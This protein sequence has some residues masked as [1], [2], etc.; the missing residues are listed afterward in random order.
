MIGT[1]MQIIENTLLWSSSNFK[2]A[3]DMV[4]HQILLAKLEKYGIDGLEYPWFQSFLE[5]RR[6]FYKETDACSDCGIPQGS[7]LGTLLFLIYINDLP[8]VL[9]Q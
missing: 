1:S 6:Q 5:S 4:Y 2:K 8:L 9:T 7:C 3:S